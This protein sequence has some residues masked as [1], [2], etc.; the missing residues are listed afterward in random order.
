MENKDASCPANP[1]CS[2]RREEDAGGVRGLAG[3]AQVSS[4]VFMEH[5]RVLSTAQ[6]SVFVGAPNIPRYAFHRPHGTSRTSGRPSS[7]S[8]LL[9]AAVGGAF[10]FPDL[11]QRSYKFPL[12]EISTV[13]LSP[14]P[15]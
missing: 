6:T 13:A 12:P 9:S 4:V 3:D 7:R 11:K 15:I 2:V 1:M 8:E 5:L 10:Y 14:P